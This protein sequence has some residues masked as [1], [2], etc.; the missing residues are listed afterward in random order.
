MPEIDMNIVI[1]RESFMYDFLCLFKE[2]WN[3]PKNYL[4]K[5]GLKENEINMIVGK[6]LDTI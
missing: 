1:P 4:R 2:K 3:D 6:L 5:I